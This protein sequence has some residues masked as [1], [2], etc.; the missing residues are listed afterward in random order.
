MPTMYIVLS[1]V[2]TREPVIGS[3]VDADPLALP[4]LQPGVAN[5]KRRSRERL[6]AVQ[7]SLTSQ[8]DWRRQRRDWRSESFK[9]GSPF[10][11]AIWRG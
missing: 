4:T 3:R 2:G 6:F 7:P 1:M 10:P 8:P 5:K 11:P 9:V